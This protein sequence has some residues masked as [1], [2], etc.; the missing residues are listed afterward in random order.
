[1]YSRPVYGGGRH[2]AVYVY[3]CQRG[4]AGR[5]HVDRIDR[6]GIRNADG[7]GNLYT[8]AIRATDAASGV[9]TSGSKR[10]ITVNA[11]LTLP[12]PAPVNGVN[13]ATLTMQFTATGGTSPYTYSITGRDAERNHDQHSV[14]DDDQ[15]V[16]RPADVRNNVGYRARA[17]R[18]HGASEGLRLH[19][20]NDHGHGH[21]H[22]GRI[23]DDGESFG[24]HEWN[25]GAA[26]VDAVPGSRWHASL[27]VRF[28]KRHAA[29]GPAFAVNAS[30]GLLSGTPTAAGSYG[31]TI[32][33]T[34]SATPPLTANA[35]GIIILQS[36][37]LIGSNITI[38]IPGAA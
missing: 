19:S 7:D 9:T 25:R 20:G 27:Y 8:F 35:Q 3:A 32:Q 33:A 29:A 10:Q 6:C 31:F 2:S 24:D 12:S 4:A 5:S 34:D 21:H 18:D 37:S 15:L 11:A 36:L 22:V 1:M 16:D 38:N 28:P 30:T 26:S 17:V 14:D 23:P 13:G